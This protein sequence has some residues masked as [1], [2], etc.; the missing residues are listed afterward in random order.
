M[1]KVGERKKSINGIGNFLEN[2]NTEKNLKEKKRKRKEKSICLE[3]KY[4]IISFEEKQK[5]WTKEMN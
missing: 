2:N 5:N 1:R 4:E 3:D